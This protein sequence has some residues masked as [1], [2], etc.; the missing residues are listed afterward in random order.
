MEPINLST[1][2]F[3]LYS[4][5]INV[6]LGIVLGLIPLVVGFI[7]HQR[8]TAFLGFVVTIVGGAILG[9]LLAIPAAAIFTWLAVTRANKSSAAAPDNDSPAS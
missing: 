6:G 4:L 2:E 5:L 9:L 8:K 3:Y 7:K 1:R